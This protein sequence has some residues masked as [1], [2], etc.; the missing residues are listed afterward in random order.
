MLKV[1]SIPILSFIGTISFA[2]VVFYDA[3]NDGVFNKGDVGIANVS[4][5][6]GKNIVKTNSSRSFILKVKSK[7]FC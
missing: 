6:D 7:P 1:I 5:T 4:V 3:N 2:G